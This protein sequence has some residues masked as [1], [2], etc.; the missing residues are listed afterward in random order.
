MDGHFAVVGARGAKTGPGAVQTG[1]AYSFDLSDPSKPRQLR[2][3]VPP[4]GAAGDLF[5]YSVDL[6]GTTAA[7]SAREHD[8]GGSNSGAV[9][10]CDVRERP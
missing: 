1:A 5:G 7:V 2:K 10:L 6:Q 8:A 9:Y 3:I 4:D